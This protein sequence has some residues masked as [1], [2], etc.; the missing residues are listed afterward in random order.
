MSS[1]ISDASETTPFDAFVDAH[2]SSYSNAVKSCGDALGC[3]WKEMGFHSSDVQTEL[4][5]I[6]TAAQQVW[7]SAV[8]DFEIQRD[9]LKRRIHEVETET[10][11]IQAQLGETMETCLISETGLRQKLDRVMKIRDQSLEMKRQRI[12]EFKGMS[13]R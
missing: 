7:Q 11:G 9:A 5:R 13:M 10:L 6:A 3:L 4:G 1:F 2:F 8:V 12:A